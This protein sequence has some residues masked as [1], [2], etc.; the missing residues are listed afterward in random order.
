MS[1]RVLTKITSKYIIRTIFDYIKDKTFS[2]N[3][4]F[5]Q[6]HFKKK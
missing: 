1:Q 4:S 6:N 3:Y 2:I 5:I